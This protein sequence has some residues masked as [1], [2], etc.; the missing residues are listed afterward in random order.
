MAESDAVESTPNPIFA[1]LK[2]E[3][4]SERRAARQARAIAAAAGA[5]PLIAAGAVTWVTSTPAPQPLE[6]QGQSPIDVRDD[7][8]A[9]EAVSSSGATT[10][11]VEQGD[12]LQSI[13]AL[14]GIPTAALLALNGLSWQTSVHAGQVLVVSKLPAP[15]LAEVEA[16]S[17]L[18]AAP[19]LASGVRADPGDDAVITHLTPEMTVNAR[20]IIQ[21]GREMRIPN[22]GIVIALATAA[23]ESHLRNLDHG[24]RDSVGLFQQR[25]TSGWGTPQQI[26]DPRYATR[27][28]FGGPASPT[29]GNNRG[30]LDIDGWQN[31]TVSE[32]AQAVQRSAF[33]NAYAKWEVSAW[34]WLFDLT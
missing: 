12:S 10:H 4:V 29:P 24:D 23:Q 11:T 7:A 21:V 27:A 20:I 28:F 2:P 15:A 18:A 8:D 25:P 16:P 9:T 17:A 3:V 26:R 30:L 14:H 33:P 34:N 32:A 22:Y 19:V 6:P 1:G 31:L 5:L 13:A